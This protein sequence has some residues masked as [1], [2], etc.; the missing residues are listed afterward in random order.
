MNTSAGLESFVETLNHV[1]QNLVAEPS[2]D[3][4]TAILKE[5]EK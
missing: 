1:Q 2:V 4:L 3:E 5:L